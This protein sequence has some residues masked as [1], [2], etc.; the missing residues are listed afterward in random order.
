ME[1][2]TSGKII[3]VFSLDGTFKVLSSTKF[4]KERYQKGNKIFLVSQDGEEVIEVTVES[5]RKNGEIDYIKT[6]EFNSKEQSLEKRGFFVKVKKDNSILSKGEFFYCDLEN[7]D[8]YD[9]N[10]KCIGKVKKVEEYP[11]QITL[12]VRHTS[13]KDFFVPYIKE[14]IKDVDIVNHKIVI[15]F[16]EGML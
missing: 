14:F 13:G 2:L 3:D 10:G 15:N 1:L 8:V 12:R 7:C 16:M 9:E 4:G 6:S 5:Y 11:A